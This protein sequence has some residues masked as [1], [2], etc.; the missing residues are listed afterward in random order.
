[1]T[2]TATRPPK[3][4]AI[5]RHQPI[6]D[7]LTTIKP[8]T[9]YAAFVALVILFSVSSPVFFS[10][11]NFLNI[12]RQTA[13]VTIM[14]VG[15]TFVIIAAQIDLS[16]ASVLALSGMTSAWAMTNISSGALVGLVVALATGA[17]VGLINGVIVTSWAVPSFLVTLGMLGI[18]RGAALMMTD[19][20]PI[21]IENPF[22]WALFGDGYI[23]GIPSPIV[24]TVLVL[25]VGFVALHLT[26]FGRRVYASGGNP[27]AAKYSGVN[28]K[29][30][31][32]AAFVIIGTLAGFAGLI[33]AARSHAARPDIA[34]GLELDVIAAVILGGTSLF[35]GKGLIMG[36]L[37]GSLMIGVLNNGLTL[38][39]VSSPAQLMV[40]GAIIIL[41]VALTRR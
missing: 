8:Y 39:G 37:L 18:A 2:T 22:V 35:G 13:L 11:D 10:Q 32:I 25:V 14:A 12:G 34:Q 36:T 24:W 28:V 1:M 27:T 40:K 20:R 29:R 23:F 26:A 41:A 31:K 9:I 19:T 3:P 30:T 4:A 38:L 15:M 5:A 21:V 33:L 6:R 17:V 7:I 16:V